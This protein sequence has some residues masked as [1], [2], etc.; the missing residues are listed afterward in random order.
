MA[1]INYIARGVVQSPGLPVPCEICVLVK[2]VDEKSR[3]DVGDAGVGT[4]TVNQNSGVLFTQ[5]Q[6]QER[7]EENV[8]NEI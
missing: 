4:T 2:T 5:N 8:R 1:I 6:L 3:G 7:N